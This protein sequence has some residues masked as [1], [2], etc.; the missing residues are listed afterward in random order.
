MQL[1]PEQQ[2]AVD[3]CLREKVS[4]ITGG[5]GTGKSTVSR[6]IV[7][8]FK[9]YGYSAGIA[10]AA[11]TGK[12]ARRLADCTDETAT[13]VHR[14]LNHPDPD[15]ITLCLVDE[16]SMLD[17][18]L[19]DLLI[20]MLPDHAH[21]VFVG[22]VDQL[23]SMGPGKV[24]AD[25]IEAVIPT[26]RLTQIHRQAAGSQIV[27]TDHAIREGVVPEINNAPDGDTF[28]FEI[29]DANRV[30]EQVVRLVTDA[31]PNKFGIPVEDIAV[32]VPQYGTSINQGCGIHRLN[33]ELQAKLNPPSSEAESW[34]NTKEE[35]Q[36]NI[37]KDRVTIPRVLRVGD[38]LVWTANDYK[39]TGF[40]NGDETV[41]KAIYEEEESGKQVTKIA[42]EGAQKPV[43]MSNL[44]AMHGWAISVHKSQGSEY[45]AG[46]VVIHSSFARMNT[47]RLLYTAATRPKELLCL[48]GEKQAM[49]Q[50]IATV[51][52]NERRTAL[53]EWLRMIPMKEAA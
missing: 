4:I 23:P 14:L 9:E 42:L 30:A 26:A 24:L 17:I 8:A 49:E 32:I 7:D 40:V 31:I 15:S 50:A 18:E 52:E 1:T 16:A 46:V 53:V 33:T 6:A 10:L 35:R 27:Q 5:P 19:A 37:R 36:W 2:A 45:R 47:R 21:L 12:A 51:Y 38:R 20:S 22:D 39:Q 44:T 48:V 41:V 29:P 25:L 13:T 11:P 34:E 43:S 28:F 3:L